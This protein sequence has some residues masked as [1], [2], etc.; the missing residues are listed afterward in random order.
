VSDDDCGIQH[1]CG[2]RNG[3]NSCEKLKKRGDE[4]DEDSDCLSS[5][6]GD[7]GR[8]ISCVI[9]DD[10]D[11]KMCISRNTDFATCG[12]AVEVSGTCMRDKE[13]KSLKCSGGG[14][15]SPQ[16][17]CVTCVQNTDCPA[18]QECADAGKSNARCKAQDFTLLPAIEKMQ[19]GYDITKADPLNPEQDTGWSNHKIFSFLY[20]K[21]DS[22]ATSPYG[23]GDTVFDVP[24]GYTFT[25]EGKCKSG[26]TYTEVTRMS[27]FE[28]EVSNSIAVS[29]GGTVP[30]YGVPVSGDVSMGN[31][32]YS[33]IQKDRRSNKRTSRTSAQCI[34]HRVNKSPSADFPDLHEDALKVLKEKL[35]FEP[36]ESNYH[37]VIKTLGTHVV[38]TASFGK[39]YGMITSFSETE[40]SSISENREGM[41]KSMS[42]GVPGVFST[43]V[44]KESEEI[45]K[46]ATALE[47][48]EGS[49]TQFSV[50]SLKTTSLQDWGDDESINTFQP[51]KIGL[52]KICEVLATYEHTDYKF[53]KEDCE[54]AM[55][56]YC[57]TKLSHEE[58]SIT[59]GT[60]VCVFDRDCD[61]NIEGSG[62]CSDEYKCTSRKMYSCGGVGKNVASCDKCMHGKNF[63]EER[64]NCGGDCAFN[65]NDNTC[66]EAG[67]SPKKCGGGVQAPNCSQCTNENNG[68]NWCKE[69][70]RWISSACK[71]AIE[72]GDRTDDKDNCHSGAKTCSHCGTEH[73][74][75]RGSCSKSRECTS[76]TCKFSSFIQ[77]HCRGT[78]K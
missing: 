23:P 62:T 53:T 32:A 61:E 14:I 76:R 67:S 72:D 12:D 7:N 66:I 65:A 71:K 17:R 42:M 41:S 57:E 36:N 35:G 38:T 46:T 4:C 54:S 59:E 21:T 31:E 68:A 39:A 51:L 63:D 27:D 15:I 49:T 16:K 56:T 60:D 2:T 52:Q 29:V 50:G 1:F 30:I 69:D 77:P 74:P 48:L 3:R 73:I 33:K 55:D 40:E 22:E 11:G 9:D 37:N 5:K 47:K 28:K 8:C 6:C 70:C 19:K 34:G 43:S 10:C 13:C 64:K 44:D 24:V 58:C 25:T 45:Q 18:M 75:L 78:C 20:S 26:M